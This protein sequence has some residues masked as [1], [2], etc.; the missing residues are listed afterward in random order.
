MLPALHTNL[1]YPHRLNQRI[2]NNKETKIEKFLNWKLVKPCHEMLTCRDFSG[3]LM[4]VKK[5]DEWT[6]GLVSCEDI[7]IHQIYK[8]FFKFHLYELWMSKLRF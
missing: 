6:F 7:K 5:I 3:K 8:Y 4:Y 1:C 2:K